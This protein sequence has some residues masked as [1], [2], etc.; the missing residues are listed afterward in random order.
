MVD[1]WHIY[2]PQSPI[3]IRFVGLLL[4]NDHVLRIIWRFRCPLQELLDQPVVCKVGNDRRRLL[5]VKV[6][7]LLNFSGQ[8][9]VALGR[10]YGGEEVEFGGHNGGNE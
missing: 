1:I 6:V 10:G 3:I 8:R 2:H 4:K 7:V 9:G 5:K